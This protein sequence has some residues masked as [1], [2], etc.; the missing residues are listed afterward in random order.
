MI[1]GQEPQ[2]VRLVD[3]SGTPELVTER[4]LDAIADLL[5]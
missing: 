4:L 2:R 5:P 1:A 3:A